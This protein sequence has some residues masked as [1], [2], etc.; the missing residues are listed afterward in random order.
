MAPG[1]VAGTRP[2][3]PAPGQSQPCCHN[4][5]GRG[6]R[7]AGP[8][9]PAPSGRSTAATVAAYAA[10]VA[11]FSYALLSGYWALGGHALVSTAGGYAA[12]I[13]RRG[14]A[15]PVLPALAAA[16][17]AAGGLLAL[18]LVRPWGR[19]IACRWLRVISAAASAL[20]IVYGAVNVLAARSSFR[21]FCTPA[22]GW[23]TRRCAGTPASGTF[24]SSHGESCSRWPQSAADSGR[25]QQTRPSSPLNITRDHSSKPSHGA[26]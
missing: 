2:G 16:A 11:A 19:V 9:Q 6:S 4:P 20:L 25:R 18:A 14:A 22:E 8:G 26:C 7:T 21:V 12:Q 17:K 10:A 24:G 5:N 1:H 15:A 13:A 3:I 23:T